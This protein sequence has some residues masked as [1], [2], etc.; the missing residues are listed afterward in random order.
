MKKNQRTIL[1]LL[2]T[3]IALVCALLFIEYL[4]ETSSDDET[5]STLSTED[6][7]EDDTETEDETE[8]DDDYETTLASVDVSEMQSVYI[9][10]TVDEFTINLDI[11]T[12]DDSEVYY[13]TLDSCENYE[14][15]AALTYAFDSFANIYSS[16]YI[17][18]Y[19]SLEEFGIGTDDTIEVVV[20]YT[21]GTELE[22]LIGLAASTT[23]GN[24]VYINGELHIIYVS[25][26]VSSKATDYVATYEYSTIT[27]DDTGTQYT[28]ELEYI[29][30]SGYNFDDTYRVE[31][32]DDIY[33]MKIVSPIQD[34]YATFGTMDDIALAV[35]AITATGVAE[36][37]ATEEDLEEY[38]LLEPYITIEFVVNDTYHIISLSESESDGTRYMIVDEDYETIYTI[39]NDSVSSWAELTPTS[40]RSDIVFMPDI[41]DVESFSIITED[42]DI[43]IDMIKTTDEENSTSTVT[44]YNYSATKDGE[45]IEYS[46]IYLSAISIL[47]LD[48]N[49]SEYDTDAY[50][51]LVYN[52]YDGTTAT[53]DYY[54]NDEGRYMAFLNDSYTATVRK[55]TMA[56]FVA[57]LEDFVSVYGD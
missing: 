53:V 32:Q 50:L 6:T 30:F 57:D 47:L 46:D 55:S 3:I 42:Y 15:A 48:F 8:E 56:E 31:D 7:E 38:G 2:I 10:N 16:R 51:T 43:T 13:Y 34:V 26:V 45:E 40:L 54:V 14:T 44:Y 39:D 11:V 18:E 17:E 12:E 33:G 21:D 4:P 1:I 24:Y 35:A 5:D 20:T 49:V 29:E 9:K 37:A 28:D 41:E 25:S 22:L 23:T 52:Y 19:S 27:Y 36:I